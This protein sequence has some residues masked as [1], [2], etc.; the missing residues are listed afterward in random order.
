M[1]SK[2]PNKI[3]MIMTWGMPRP[4]NLQWN[5]KNKNYNKKIYKVVKERKGMNTKTVKIHVE[6]N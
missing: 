6:S 3:I 1:L 5:I 2:Y 4:E